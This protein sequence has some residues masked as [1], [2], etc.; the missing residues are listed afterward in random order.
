[1]SEAPKPK[2]NQLTGFIALLLVFFASIFSVL[3]TANDMLDSASY[4]YKGKPQY[5]LITFER[6]KYFSP[7]RLGSFTKAYEYEGLYA[8]KKT[9]VTSCLIYS[10]PIYF[11]KKQEID[12]FVLVFKKI[13]SQYAIIFN[14]LDPWDWFTVFGIP[15]LLIVFMSSLMIFSIKNW[16]DFFA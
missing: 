9:L 11:N 12:S 5:A 8:C 10:K 15:L 14:P 16:R 1:M 6:I 4:F 3:L 7:R 2:Y 13:N